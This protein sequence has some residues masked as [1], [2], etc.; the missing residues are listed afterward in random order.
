MGEDPTLCLP[1]SGGY[2]WSSHMDTSH[3][4]F[5]LNL[6]TSSKQDEICKDLFLRKVTVTGTGG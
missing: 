4:G 6:M 5:G 3:M 1:S 2:Q